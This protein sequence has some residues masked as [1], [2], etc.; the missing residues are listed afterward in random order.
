M[1]NIVMDRFGFPPEVIER[2][3][4]SIPVT[5]TVL[6]GTGWLDSFWTAHD[7]HSVT[8]ERKTVS[9]LSNRVDELETQLKNAL[10]R[11]D[12]VLLLIEGI[13]DCI[14]NS[15]ILYKQSQRNGMFYRDRIV[16]RPLQYYLGFVYRLDK[17]GVT[18]FWTPSKKATATAVVE[19]VKASNKPEF[20]TF[21]RYIR[22]KPKIPQPDIVVQ[23][24]MGL[25]LG[26]KVA[27]ALAGKFGSVWNVLHASPQE[28]QHIDGVGTKTVDKLFKEIGKT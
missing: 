22:P 20:S 4:Q 6:G 16:N 26:E 27:I 28:L 9:D 23:R 8:L 18:T 7:N 15:T 10:V 1:L 14:E 17:L 13:M 2:V 24:L 11:A 25:G 21:R 5:E 19:F 3:K 12:E